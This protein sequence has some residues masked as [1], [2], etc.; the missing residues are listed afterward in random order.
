MYWP[1]P[2]EVKLL[3][4]LAELR[5]KAGRWDIKSIVTSGR[6]LVFSFAKEA[7]GKADSLFAKMSGEVRIAEPKTVYL[8]L[9]KNYLEPR[10][11]MS[12]LRKIFNR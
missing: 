1:V 6:D 10:T 2:D 5:I 11:L 4:D 7:S 3:L 9:G 12:I 8:R